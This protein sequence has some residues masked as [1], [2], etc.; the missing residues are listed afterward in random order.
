LPRFFPPEE[1]FNSLSLRDLLEAREAYHVHLVNMV[2]VVATAIGRYRVRKAIAAEKPRIASEAKY[3]KNAPPKTLQNTVVTRWSWPCILVFVKKWLTIE[4][5]NDEPDQVVPRFLYLPDGK[6]V[7]TC[8]ILATRK[9]LPLPP[10]TNLSFPGEIMGGGYPI[11]TEVQGQE[12]ISSVGCLVTDGHSVYALT[13]KHVV[14]EKKNIISSSEQ[15]RSIL[16]FMNGKRLK[17]GSAHPKQIGKKLFSEVYNIWPGSRAYCTLDAGLIHIDDIS[18]WTAQVFGVGEIGEPVDLHIDSISVDLIG[19][20]VRAF[21]AAS[22][23]MVGEIQALFYRY[24]SIGG[25]DYVCD[26]L[27]GKREGEQQILMSRPGDSGTIWFYD[28]HPGHV[29]QRSKRQ[30]EEEGERTSGARAHR[31]P[32][33]ALQWGGHTLMDNRGGEVELSFALATSLSTILRELDVDLVRGWNIGLSEYWGKLGH[34]KIAAK[35]CEL[36]SNLKLRRLMHNNLDAIAFNDDKIR[37]GQLRRIDAKQFVPLADVP[38]LVWRKS[39]KK[40]EANHFAV[41]DEEGKGEFRRKTLLDMIAED[42]GNVSIQ[43]WNKFYDSIG[44][45]FK[46]G[47]LP[48]RVWQIYNEMVKF[49]HDDN[50]KKFVCSAGILA[51]YIGDACQPL[52][53]SKLHHGRNKEEEKVHS[54]YEIEMLDR[55][56]ADVI[57]GVNAKAHSASA[58]A[59][60]RGGRNAALSVIDLMIKTIQKLPPLDIIEAYNEAKQSNNGKKYL[61]DAV[62]DRTIS[63]IVNGCIKLASIWESAWREGNGKNISDGKLRSIDKDDLMMLYNDKRFLEAFRLQEPE[64]QTIL[65]QI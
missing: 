50:T 8:V 23:E 17:I 38:D 44:T 9:E 27:I 20:P 22:G 11:V 3:I 41:M 16:T 62:G 35:A 46:R 45:N 37:K 60:V 36:V 2:N 40:D 6:M 51:H 15:P 21:G 49:A 47:A 31:L 39:R 59:D 57:A 48:F 34:Y 1:N 33:I 58:K 18:Y 13:N 7:P 28:A 64:F 4:E 19:C 43:V 63:C 56:A 26:F 14:G 65:Q 54:Y 32:P 61:F 25:F 29:D 5:M 55:Y 24:K 52:H 42:P 12:R 30:E 53:V 10:L